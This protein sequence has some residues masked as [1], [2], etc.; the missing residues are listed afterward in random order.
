MHD[1]KWDIRCRC[2]PFMEYFCRKAAKKISERVYTL[3]HAGVSEDES[4]R[5]I[6]IDLA[7]KL[8]CNWIY[9]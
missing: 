5:Q 6:A 1:L 2:A 8:D 3:E 4:V 9:K 7:L